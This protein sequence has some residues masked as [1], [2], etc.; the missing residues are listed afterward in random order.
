MPLD[1]DTRVGK[2]QLTAVDVGRARLADRERHRT[3]PGVGRRE[4]LRLPERDRVA[5]QIAEPRLVEQR[6][7]EDRRVIELGGPR[8]ARV[9]AGDGRG[10][11]ADDGVVGVGVK[12]VIVVARHHQGLGRRELVIDAGAL[13]SF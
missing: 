7:A 8:P 2:L 5:M 9:A 13:R 3:R 1:H 6:R 10:V 11:R 4:F 12:E